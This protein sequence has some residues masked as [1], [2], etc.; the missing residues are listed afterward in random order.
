MKSLAENVRKV[1]YNN[2]KTSKSS[3]S[4]ATRLI[5]ALVKIFELF[6]FSAHFVSPCKCKLGALHD[7]NAF[8]TETCS[9]VPKFF[10]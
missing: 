6:F 3:R 4:Q 1:K 2:E 10:L 9:G 7:R 5:I 8:L